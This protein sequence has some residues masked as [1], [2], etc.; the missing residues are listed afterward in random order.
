[1]H[2]VPRTELG[3]FGKPLAFPAVVAIFAWPGY[4]A[5]TTAV[6]LG[7]SPARTQATASRATTRDPTLEPPSPT[8]NHIDQSVDGPTPS[9]ALLSGTRSPTNSP[10]P[11]LRTIPWFC[12]CF[13]VFHLGFG[14]VWPNLCFCK[15]IYL[16]GATRST[17]MVLQAQNIGLYLK[18]LLLALQSQINGGWSWGQSSTIAVRWCLR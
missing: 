6:E 8:P 13:C 2:P 18:P 9:A 17:R 12:P 15:R 1:M 5:L 11:T 16:L 14:L 10:A 4:Q 3:I 7:A